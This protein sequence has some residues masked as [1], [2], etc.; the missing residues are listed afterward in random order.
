MPQFVYD[1]I[2]KKIVKRERY[3]IELTSFSSVFNILKEHSQ[4]Q[5]GDGY[6]RFVRLVKFSAHIPS[7]TP[8]RTYYEGYAY[9]LPKML[10]HLKMNLQCITSL[11]KT[12]T[13]NVDIVLQKPPFTFI[14]EN[15]A[16][17]TQS[18]ATGLTNNYSGSSQL[19]VSPDVL[20]ETLTE[21]YPFVSTTN[22]ISQ[23]FPV[24]NGEITSS[25]LINQPLAPLS[26]ITFNEVFV[27]GIISSGQIDADGL[28]VDYENAIN[29]TDVNNG[30]DCTS[31]EF[32]PVT[33]IKDVGTTIFNYRGSKTATTKNGYARSYNSYFYKEDPTYDTQVLTEVPL[34]ADRICVTMYLETL[35]WRAQDITTAHA[36]AFND[37][38]ANK[39]PDTLVC[40]GKE[41]QWQNLL[42]DR[43][44]MF[45]TE[46]GRVDTTS[47]T[48]ISGTINENKYDNT[49][50]KMDTI[51]LK[52]Y[53]TIEVLLVDMKK[54]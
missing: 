49:T 38:V 32:T 18:S 17:K 13:T 53:A 8:M 54:K 11:K 51:K 19:V 40:P 21:I 6:K 16:G 31:Y 5:Y 33:T 24:N 30:Y 50:M 4:F 44:N 46:Y 35:R 28:A 22:I 34:R 36:A 12:T 3:K 14:S 39:W 42:M 47:A 37:G 45:D 26:D 52:F 27:D 20:V 15:T 25:N 43:Y 29:E 48:Y 41:M 23:L 2:I 1:D 10:S 9:V 7:Q